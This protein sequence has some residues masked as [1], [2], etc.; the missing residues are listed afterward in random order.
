MECRASTL[1]LLSS[2]QFY[3][4]FL[5]KYVLTILRDHKKDEF[6]TLEKFSKYVAA[7]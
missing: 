6:M 2:T 1:A 7:H 5:E 3:A 4:L